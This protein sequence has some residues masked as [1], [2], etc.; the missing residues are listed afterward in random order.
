MEKSPKEC[1]NQHHLRNNKYCYGIPALIQM[2]L[3]SD[4]RPEREKEKRGNQKGTWA[5]MVHDP[6]GSTWSPATH[7]ST[8]QLHVLVLWYLSMSFCGRAWAACH[9]PMPM[10]MPMC[11]SGSGTHGLYF[12]HQTVKHFPIGSNLQKFYSKKSQKSHL[13]SST[14]TEIHRYTT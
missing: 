13:A 5:G 8:H 10:P 4:G 9:M 6:W 12:R 14:S 2:V 3:H 11:I 7:R 1:K